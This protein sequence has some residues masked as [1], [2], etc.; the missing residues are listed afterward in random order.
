MSKVNIIAPS[1]EVFRVYCREKGY[2]PA[3]VRYINQVNQ[4]IGQK[5]LTIVARDGR[6]AFDFSAQQNAII[7]RAKELHYEIAWDGLRLD[8]D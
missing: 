5:D 2:L 4:L 1:I 3:Q 7:N 6:G 8:Q